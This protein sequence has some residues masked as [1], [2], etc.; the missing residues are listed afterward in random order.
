MASKFM[1]RILPFID[2]DTWARDRSRRQM[3]SQATSQSERDD[4]MGYFVD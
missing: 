2:S 1:H 4:I 3:L